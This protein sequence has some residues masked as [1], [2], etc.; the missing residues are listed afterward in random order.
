M[1]NKMPV[2]LSAFTLSVDELRTK[3][4]SLNTAFEHMAAAAGRIERVLNDTFRR[5]GWRLRTEDSR[6][7]FQRPLVWQIRVFARAMR[8]SPVSIVVMTTWFRRFVDAQ[9]PLL[10]SR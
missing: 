8:R 4:E 5:F 3:V 10:P 7:T 1:T 2:D 6:V 9:P